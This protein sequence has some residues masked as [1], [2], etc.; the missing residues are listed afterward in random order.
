MAPTGLPN[1]VI[2][3]QALNDWFSYRVS[4]YSFRKEIDFTEI[5]V[6][7]KQVGRPKMDYALTLNT[8]KELAMVENNEQ[9]KQARRYFLWCKENLQYL[10]TVGKA[11]FMKKFAKMFGILFFVL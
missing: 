5:S 1:K 2:F 3:E 11:F 8:A 9:G 6:K 7:L 10:P 4:Q